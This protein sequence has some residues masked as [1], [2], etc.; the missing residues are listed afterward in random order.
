LRVNHDFCSLKKNT[1]YT[2]CFLLLFI[3]AACE[4]HSNKQD[5]SEQTAQHYCGSC[6]L[7][8]TADVLDKTT[9]KNNVLPAMATKLG[10]DYLYELHLNKK[11]GEN[12][13]SIEDWKKILGYYITKAPETMLPQQ[14]K[15][16]NKYTDLFSVTKIIL[17]HDSFPSASFVKIDPGNH[18]IYTAN[19]F[20]S[21]LN[22][23]TDKLKLLTKYNV[24]GVIVDMNFKNPLLEAGERNGILTNIG[25]MNPNDLR[26]GTVD[27]FSIARNGSVTY[28]APLFYNLPRPVQASFFNAG[29]NESPGYLVCG[30][31]NVREGAL[32]FINKTDKGKF[33]QTILRALPGAIKA[34]I[35]DYDHDGLP[36]ILVLMAQAQEGIYLLINKGN[37]EF[38]T[39]EILRFPPTNG[40]N[41]FELD[42]FN[43]DGFKDILYTCGDNADYSSNTLKSYHGV[44]IFLNDRHNNFSQKYFFPIHGCFKA[45]AKDFDKDGD[46]DIAAISYFPDAK[47]QPQES[48]VYLE[49]KKYLQFEASTIKEFNEGKW[50]TMDAGDVDGDGDDDIVLGSLVPPVEG[51]QQ[52]WKESGIQKVELMLLKNKK[53]MQ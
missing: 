40:S 32:L 29:K 41:Y 2:A 15:P 21:T 6:H 22:I 24:H 7:F 26:E 38:V 45:M 1:K 4:N 36:D 20:D 51:Q 14:R 10:I 52:K 5:T 37:G 17:S 46:L 9:W 16:V 48:F 8:P 12:H 50:L 23:Y 13:I 19:S 30:F 53:V 31:G 39:K 43:N 18:W 34:Y 28:R 11:S 25:I 3:A 35:D 33:K 47:N 27:T 44:Y 49:Q 42:D